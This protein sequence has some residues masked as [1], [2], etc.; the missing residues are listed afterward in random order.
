MENSLT[1]LPQT[2]KI[3]I[4]KETAACPAYQTKDGAESSP[5]LSICFVNIAESVSQRIVHATLWASVHSDNLTDRFI[6]VV[7]INKTG[8]L[9]K[10]SSDAPTK[11]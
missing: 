11:S 9:I 10:N 7:L 5:S 1:N 8:L 4:C 6:M 2:E 3:R